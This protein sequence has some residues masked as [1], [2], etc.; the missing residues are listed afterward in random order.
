MTM[1]FITGS[2]DRLVERRRNRF[3]IKAATSCCTCARPSARFGLAAESG[4][5]NVC[6]VTTAHRAACRAARSIRSATASG[7]E[8]RDMWLEGMDVTLAPIWWAIACWT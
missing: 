6:C 5:R 4:L 2:T 1:V 3:L 8:T 7:C